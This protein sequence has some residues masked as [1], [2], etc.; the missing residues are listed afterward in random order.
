MQEGKT[1]MDVA[2]EAKHTGIAK[3]MKP[4]TKKV[5]KPRWHFSRKK[6]AHS[7]TG[8]DHVDGE[9]EGS[10]MHDMRRSLSTASLA[11]NQSEQAL[12]EESYSEESDPEPCNWEME[13]EL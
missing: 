12:S 9:I 13:I 11:S 4:R 7:F 10:R 2:V 1:A 8:S 6:L 5:K 3:L